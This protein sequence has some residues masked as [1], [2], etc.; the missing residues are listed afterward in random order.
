MLKAG[1]E[2]LTAA[3]RVAV[4][5]GTIAKFGTALATAFQSAIEWVRQF[6]ASFDFNKTAADMQTFVSHANEVFDKISGYATNAGNIVKLAYGVMSA[7]TNFVLTGI[8]SIGEAF[9][10]VARDVMLGV[11]TIR[12]GLAKITFGELSESF[13]LAAEDA[14]S[15]AQGFGEASVAMRVKAVEAFNDMADSAETAV[16]GFEGLANAAQETKVATTQGADAVEVLREALRKESEA[17]Y[18]AIEAATKKEEADTAAA[19][20]AQKHAL[21]LAE[22]SKAI[23]ELKAE[24]AQAIKTGDW[25]AVSRLHQEINAKIKEGE[26]ISKQASVATQQNA[27]ANKELSKAVEGTSVALE[28]KAQ[29]EKADAELALS[30]LTLKKASVSAAIA[31]AEAQGDEATA[32]RLK[33][34]LKRIEIEIIKATVAVQK[35]E[36]EG[37]IAVAQ[38]KMA[39]LKASGDLTDAKRTEL[40]VAIKTAQAKVNLANATGQS[41]K[42]LEAEIR[43]LST[44]TGAI[45]Q[46]TAATNA[47]TAATNRRSDA[48]E[49]IMM[50]YTLSADYTKRQIELLKEETEA[51]EAAAEAKRKYWKVDKEGYSV[52]ANGNRIVV[53][54]ETQA[55]LYNKAKDAGL[56]AEQSRRLADQYAPRQGGP[57][58]DNNAFWNELNQLRQ[59]NELDAEQAANQQKESGQSTKRI[60]DAV[61]RL[62]KQSTTQRPPALPAPV[63]TSTPVTT[64]AP[65]P[66][67]TPPQTGGQGGSM[68]ITPAPTHV[69]HITIPGI[70]RAT[71]KFDN[72][73]DQAQ[74]ESMLRALT[75]AAGVAQ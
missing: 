8:Y 16:S 17:A 44:G 70:G 11:A 48:W 46:H 7:G 32:T 52:D 53:T 14:R 29:L 43:A 4:D 36:A 42:A 67:P 9:A 25:E 75:S 33:I 24:Y 66:A 60:G 69:S 23:K 55:S 2:E 1:V 34:D 39:E 41:T 47:N 27:A 51:I 56:T 57:M 21:A 59:Q 68:G 15:T 10:G 62:E 12:D 37:A 20:A 72:P 71:A 38:A 54:A 63:P 58:F 49:K 28:R 40:E 50:Q 26:A 73:S 74:L 65:T 22:N 64:P 61:E 45:G 5:N 6:S 19:I 13:K 30:A 31:V 18:A 35:I 3:L